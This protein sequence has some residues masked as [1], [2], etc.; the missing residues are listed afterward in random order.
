M[1]WCAVVRLLWTLLERRALQRLLVDARRA[2]PYSIGARLRGGRPGDHARGVLF[3]HAVS[4]RSADL[5]A[6][7]VDVADFCDIATLF[8]ESASRVVVSAD[9][10]SS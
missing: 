3:R 5:P 10:Q 7:D 2:G 6:V 8:N 4:E 9:P 1:A